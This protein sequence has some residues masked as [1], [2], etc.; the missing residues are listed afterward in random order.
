MKKEIKYYF[1]DLLF[2]VYEPYVIRKEKMKATRMWH[3]GVKQCVKMYKEIGSPRVYL[4]FDRKHMV[5]APMTF[6]PNK[7]FR[8]SL[9]QLRWMGKMK[10]FEKIKNVDDMKRFSYYY[11]P[12]KW[13]ALGC[14]E[15]NKVREEKLKLWM[16]YYMFHLSVPMQKCRQYRQ[17]MAKRHPAES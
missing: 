13:G 10:G 11:T 6:E 9:R 4:F 14:E 2:K 8:P 5:W 7:K 16:T 15:D 1:K 12:S 17:R 3:D